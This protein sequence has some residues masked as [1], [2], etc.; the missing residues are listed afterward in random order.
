[1]KTATQPTPD[2]IEEACQLHEE[3]AEAYQVGQVEQAIVLFRRAL[4]LFEEHEG[5]D[6]PDV[7]AVLGSLGAIYENRSEYVAAEEAY[8]R[9]AQIMDATQVPSD[10]GEDD[11]DML[12][13][14]LEACANHGRILRIQ[15]RYTQ[16]ALWLKALFWDNGAAKTSEQTMAR[17]YEFMPVRRPDFVAR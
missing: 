10:G 12:Q 16:A 14:R 5:A 15:G 1:M 7:A 8:A 17:A 11:A 13:L 4:A 2:P 6:H 9:A 3:A